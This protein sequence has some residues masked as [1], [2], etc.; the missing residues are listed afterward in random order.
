MPQAWI[1]RTT[2][3][4]A[5]PANRESSDSARMIAKERS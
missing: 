2:T 5:T 3:R 4:T 1:I